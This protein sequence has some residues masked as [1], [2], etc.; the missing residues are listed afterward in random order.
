MNTPKPP[1][2]SILV[3]V[4]NV[5]PYLSQCL[6]SLT[7][8]TL[9][10]IEIICINDGST[11]GSLAILKEFAH[12][13]PRI[14]IITKKNTGYGD[15]MNRALAAA[16]GEYIGILEPDDYIEPNAF[17]VMYAAA[18]E[19]HADVVKC[20][21]FRT[22]DSPKSGV[23]NVKTSEISELAVINPQE[24]RYV[25]QFA[26]A[27]WSAIYRRSF[28]QDNHIDFLPTPGASYQD[29]GFTFKVWTLARTVVLLP[30]AFVH[31]R[32]DNANSS[33]NNPGKVNCVVDEY[34]EIETFLCERGIFPEFGETMAA[35]KFRN[36]HWNFQRL[37]KALS[38][39]FYQTWRE[40]LLS[41]R[42]E[43]LLQKSNFSKKDWLALQLILKHPHLAYHLLRLRHKLKH[44]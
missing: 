22:Q 20:N 40:D 34:N 26:P 18:R 11:D 10:D 29:L 28:L 13:D 41:A 33:I 42:E 7:D 16:H 38:R 19:H 44:H 23:I 6:A 32:I 27:I 1:K 30:D 15:S 31:Y 12:N 39:E 14:T 9:T 21:N 25:F 4:Y 37:D 8:Q 43:G 3:P 24:D 35:T 17:E 5:E 2:V 36:Y